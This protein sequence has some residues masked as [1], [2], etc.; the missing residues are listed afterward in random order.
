MGQLVRVLSLANKGF[1]AW[2]KTGTRG[3]NQEMSVGYGYRPGPE[4]PAG[5][6]PNVQ[7]VSYS[8]VALFPPFL[9]P[10]PARCRENSYIY[11]VIISDAPSEKQ[12]SFG[13][14][15]NGQAAT[16]NRKGKKLLYCGGG[17]V[18]RHSSQP[19]YG[20]DQSV[21][22]LPTRRGAVLEHIIEYPGLGASSPS[23]VWRSR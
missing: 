15:A 12:R 23:L 4:L 10:V 20:R 22:M 5:G 21:E 9:P 2:A 14:G 18:G 1:L 17:M 6:D 7:L 11:R 3:H 8:S 16:A 19:R 13:F